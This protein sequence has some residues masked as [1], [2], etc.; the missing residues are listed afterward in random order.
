[1]DLI[2]YNNKKVEEI[3]RNILKNDL[4]ILIGGRKS[5]KMKKKKL[6]KTK[7]NNYNIK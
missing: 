3:Y 5:K 1:M 7:S 6:R 2:K 4:N